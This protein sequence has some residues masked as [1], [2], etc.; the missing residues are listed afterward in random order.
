MY[1]ANVSPM[2]VTS[3]GTADSVPNVL[4][5]PDLQANLFSQK[6]AK[7]EGAIIWLSSDG[8]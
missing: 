2:R 7:R 4:F 6:Q 3:F 5:L 1:A 8:I